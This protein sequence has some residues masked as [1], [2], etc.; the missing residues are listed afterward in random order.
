MW[1]IFISPHQHSDTIQSLV[2]HPAFDLRLL[3][4]CV[5]HFIAERNIILICGSLVFFNWRF[6]FWLTRELKMEIVSTAELA[7]QMNPAKRSSLIP[8]PLKAAL[9]AALLVRT[10]ARHWPTA[11]RQKFSWFGSNPACENTLREA[12]WLGWNKSIFSCVF[13]QMVVWWSRL[14]LH[15]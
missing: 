12:T 6:F 15:I 1:L 8:G 14:S 11:L 9:A 3:P 10:R 7:A 5:T 2:S 4:L 13:L